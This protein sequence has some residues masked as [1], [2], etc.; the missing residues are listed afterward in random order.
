MKSWDGGK[1]AFGPLGCDSPFEPLRLLD[2][3]QNIAYR[4][5]CTL[6]CEIY[7]RTENLPCSKDVVTDRWYKPG[8]LVSFLIHSRWRIVQ[9]IM[10]SSRFPR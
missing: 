7:N 4:G 1:H 10:L 9:A 6:S 8:R 5:D 2:L 3:A